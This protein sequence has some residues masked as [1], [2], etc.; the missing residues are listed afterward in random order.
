MK[1]FFDIILVI[2]I[3]SRQFPVIQMFL[4]T[5][6]A[7]YSLEQL[8][9]IHLYGS[10]AE[11]ELRVLLRFDFRMFLP[12]MLHW[13][14]GWIQVLNIGIIEL[15]SY[16]PSSREEIL[17]RITNSSEFVYSGEYD[18]DY[19]ID[20]LKTKFSRSHG[21]RRHPRF[22]EKLKVHFRIENDYV[23]EY[24]ANI[25]AGGMF[26][27]GRTNVATRSRMEVSLALPGQNSP[28]SALV[29]VIHII[30]E[31]VVFIPDEERAF[32]FGVRFVSFLNDGEFVLG[33]YLSTL[34]TLPVE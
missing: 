19:V 9:E 12:S 3:E 2:P 8:P 28:V 18:F 24:T 6:R 29:E 23:G 30:P 32:G 26:I 10:I 22:R 33:N 1:K 4:R 16:H 5:T 11:S 21:V 25:S 20:V 15:E 31:D 34:S 13:L 17:D 7:H 14:S 27:R